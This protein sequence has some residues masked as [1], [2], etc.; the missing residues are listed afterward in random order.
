[1]RNETKGTLELTLA[2][3]LSGTIGIFVVESGASPFN[4]VLL[5]CLFGAAALGAY[6]AVRGYFTDHG[7]TP[8]KFG[9]AALGD[10]PRSRAC[11]ASSPSVG[12]SDSRT[13][14]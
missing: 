1:M 7:L 3:V 4:V 13:F 10:V 9:L 12:R 11:R 8:R 5:R 2:M 14:G 6:A